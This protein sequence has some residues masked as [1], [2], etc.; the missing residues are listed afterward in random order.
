MKDYKK[1]LSIIL[2]LIFSLN[3]CNPITKGFEDDVSIMDLTSNN[4]RSLDLDE[5]KKFR[6][7]DLDFD[8][9]DDDDDEDLDVI[10]IKKDNISKVKKNN[11]KLTTNKNVQIHNVVNVMVDGAFQPANSLQGKIKNKLHSAIDTFTSPSELCCWVASTVAARYLSDA[12]DVFVFDN[13]LKRNVLQEAIESTRDKS[14]WDNYEK[15]LQKIC[16][17]LGWID[18]NES[19]LKTQIF[20]TLYNYLDY[21]SY[22]AFSKIKDIDEI[23]YRRIMSDRNGTN[24][25]YTLAWNH[26]LKHLGFATK[27]YKIKNDTYFFNQ[28]YV[29]VFT[30]K[31]EGSAKIRLLT[32]FLAK[33]TNN[34]EKKLI[35]DKVE[36]D[37]LEN[38]TTASQIVL[39]DVDNSSNTIKLD[40]GRDITQYFDYNEDTKLLSKK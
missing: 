24:W 35:L 16:H 22:L 14:T 17:G 4:E 18:Q 10:K 32:P 12:A 34:I 33:R 2:S 13:M 27:I 28:E 5:S 8:D 29:I 6:C 15:E 21:T 30:K 9:D 38:N 11:D 40:V 1:K 3:V 26:I 37:I 20:S 25:V 31:L 7:L 36:K 23:S 39:E 19:G